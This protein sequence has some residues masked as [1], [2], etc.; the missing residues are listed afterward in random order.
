MLAGSVRRVETDTG[1]ALDEIPC[2][3]LGAVTSE[4][5]ATTYGDRYKYAGREWD[6]AVK[7]YYDRRRVRPGRR[8]IP[9][10]GSQGGRHE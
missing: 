3:G 4:S 6:A 9:V 5:A 8:A 7:A 10:R 2:N 1:M